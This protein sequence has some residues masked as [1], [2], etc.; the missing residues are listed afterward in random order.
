[1]PRTCRICGCT[2]ERA[3]P[4]GCTWVGPDLCS[5]CDGRT[6]IDLPDGWEAGRFDL[7]GED[8]LLVR[9]AL[10]ELVAFGRE[11]GRFHV[12]GLR[13]RPGVAL[14]LTQLEHTYFPPASP[15][16]A[17]FVLHWVRWEDLEWAVA[18]IPRRAERFAR[19]TAERLGLR[20]ADGVPTLIDGSGSP[21][22]FPMNGDNVFTLEYA[23]ARLFRA[24]SQPEG[25]THLMD[26]ESNSVGELL[27]RIRD[28]HRRN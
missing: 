23:D 12:A 8:T 26:A 2:D 27:A 21:K 9:V 1:M 3:C 19:R 16:N 18:S 28:L 4:G 10:R 6:M 25:V 14:W 11:P 22:F 7:K 20:L 15:R 5:A 13:G 24:A 17:E